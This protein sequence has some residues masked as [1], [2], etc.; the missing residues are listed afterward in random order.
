VNDSHRE[1]FM[2]PKALYH[3]EATQEVS[4]FYRYDT[5]VEAE[6]K[7]EAERLFRDAVALRLISREYLYENQYDDDDLQIESIEQTE[8]E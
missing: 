4:R 2:M 3:C 1:R 8:G 6:S 5:S 7:D